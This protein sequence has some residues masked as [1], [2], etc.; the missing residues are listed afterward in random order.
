[1]ELFFIVAYQVQIQRRVLCNSLFLLVLLSITI[2]PVS[3]GS[4]PSIACQKLPGSNSDDSDF[5]IEHP[6][7][8]GHIAPGHSELSPSTVSCKVARAH[9]LGCS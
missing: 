1:M 7:D 5:G 4:L 8:K 6:A 2:L 3:A 9:V